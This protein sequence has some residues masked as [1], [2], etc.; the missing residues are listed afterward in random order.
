MTA[1]LCQRASNKRGGGYTMRT[2]LVMPGCG[3]FSNSAIQRTQFTL[4]ELRRI[5]VA[6]SP[7][8]RSSERALA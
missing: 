8:V 5:K 4:T 3:L 2:L 1:W 6:Y 7:I